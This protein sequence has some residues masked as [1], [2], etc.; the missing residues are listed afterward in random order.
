MT[1]V[2]E[3]HPYGWTI[4]KHVTLPQLCPMDVTHVDVVQ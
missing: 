1:V 3:I 2:I 4:N